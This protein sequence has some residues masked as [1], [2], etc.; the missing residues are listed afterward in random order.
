MVTIEKEYIMTSMLDNLRERVKNY[1]EVTAK[2]LAN[3]YLG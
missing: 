2:N 3:I 1:R